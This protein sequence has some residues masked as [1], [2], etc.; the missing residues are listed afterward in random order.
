MECA[1]QA[2]A[3]FLKVETQRPIYGRIAF[4]NIGSQRVLKKCG[5]KKVGTG[6]FFANAL[7][8]E[9]EEIIYE[10]EE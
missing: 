8:Q 9:I 1:S 7:G 10:L 5:V 4:D 6:H 3:E 2:L